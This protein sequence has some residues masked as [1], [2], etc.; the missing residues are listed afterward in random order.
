MRLSTVSVFLLLCCHTHT[1]TVCRHGFVDLILFILF[2]R[3]S[4]PSAWNGQISCLFCLISL[5]YMSLFAAKYSMTTRTLTRI[6]GI[7]IQQGM[8]LEI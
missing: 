7:M 5:I 3:Y 6:M 1:E 8:L 4:W 2:H